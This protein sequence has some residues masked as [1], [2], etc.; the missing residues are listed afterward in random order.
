MTNGLISKQEAFS[1]AIRRFPRFELPIRRLIE[2]DG[3]F[4]EICEELAEAD[5]ALSTVDNAPTQLRETRRTE[6]QEL[7]DC[8]V[9]EVAAAIRSDAHVRTAHRSP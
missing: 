5:L 1:A 7:I 6:W 3:T 9:G 2:T 8:L 4:R